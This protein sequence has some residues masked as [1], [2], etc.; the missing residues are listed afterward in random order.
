IVQELRML[1][2]R[3]DVA[4]G[5]VELGAVIRGAVKLASRELR[6]RAQLIEEYEGVPAVW[7]NGPRLGQVVLNLLINAAYAITPGKPAENEVRLVAR[8]HDAGSVLVEVRDTGSGIPP[9]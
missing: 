6:D 4:L 7:G 8:A 5:P 1:S 9:E 2:R 3:D